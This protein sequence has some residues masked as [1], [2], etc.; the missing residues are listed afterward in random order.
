M[1]RQQLSSRVG[2]EGAGKESVEDALG[3]LMLTV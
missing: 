2:Q 1:T 3:V